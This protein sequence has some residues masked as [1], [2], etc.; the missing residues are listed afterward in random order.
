[1]KRDYQPHH[2]DPSSEEVNF[3]LNRMTKAVEEGVRFTM[4]EGMR[5]EDFREWMRE[6]AEKCRKTQ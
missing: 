5:S 2:H 1:M 6:N 4:P 3:D